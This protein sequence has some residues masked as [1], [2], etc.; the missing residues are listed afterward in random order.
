MW[1]LGVVV[2]GVLGQHPAEVPLS[3]DQHPVGQLGADCQHE[4]FGEAVRPRAPGRDL[5]H[6]DT[7]IRQHRVKRVRELAGAV[8]DEE[9]EP[10]DVFAEVHDEVAG[11]L[12]GPGPV[13]M[14]GHA[15]DVQ[16]AVAD[17]ECEQDVEP[18]QRHR[19]V[20][21]KKSTASMP[22]AWVRRN[23]RQLV[24]VCR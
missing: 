24:S 23:C 2:R 19:A 9:S 3:E 4:A 22:A 1:P 13:G 8:A 20:D 10:R 18:A 16:G 6:F 12:G 14:R 17:L 11:L 7:R 15:E 5:D 21:W